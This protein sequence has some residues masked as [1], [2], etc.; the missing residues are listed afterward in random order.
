MTQQG[1]TVASASAKPDLNAVK[2]TPEDIKQLQSNPSPETRSGF[3][4][5]FGQQY[6]DFVING[7]E[8]FA[9]SILEF[10]AKDIDATVRQALAE[11]IAES[12]NL[13][14]DLA[15]DLAC[16]DIEIARP[17]LERSPVLQDGRLAEIVL[18]HT[19]QY[20]LAV[21]GRDAISE[22]LATA[23][24]DS[25]EPDVIMRL[26]NNDGA[27]ISDQALCLLAKTYHDDDEIQDRLAK[28]P[29]LPPE[30]VD[31]LLNTIG[32]KLEWDLVKDRSMDPEEARRLVSATKDRTAARLAKKQQAEKATLRSMHERMAAG[33]LT[34]LDILG[35]L[36]DCDVERFEAS[37][38]TMA[39]IDSVKTRHL[40][41]NM[42]KRCVAVLC[43]RAGLGTP[44]YMAVRMALDLADK[45]VTEAHAS[46][47]K[48][49]T[50]TVRFVQ[51]QY[52]RIRI[53]KKLISQMM[54]H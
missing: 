33:D 20:A 28:R 47:F 4:G 43:L 18:S 42:D 7:S 19:M 36:R 5:K 6:D 23:L 1:A 35:F 49:A 3:A 26:I 10:L 8:K 53:D 2:I 15:A 11:S 40:L 21:A 52:D 12:P 32:E 29:G 45:R 37:L 48:Y 22:G 13:P 46:R 24:I 34:A 41:Y 39:G 17:I 14:S 30:V 27:Q 9:T 54:Q 44:Q 25:D 51:Q 38:S 16:D 50:D 31:Q